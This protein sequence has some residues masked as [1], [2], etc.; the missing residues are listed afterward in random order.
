[1]QKSLLPPD[2]ST[3][4]RP[5][6]NDFAVRHSDVQGVVVQRYSA[7]A[8]RVVLPPDLSILQVEPGNASLETDGKHIRTKDARCRVDIDET[9][10]LSTAV[11]GLYNCFP[12]HGTVPVVDGKDLAVVEP[13]E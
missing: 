13:T 7:V 6:R 10:Q 3:G 12:L 4:A 5:H 9:L 1:M 2:L 8:G 11:R